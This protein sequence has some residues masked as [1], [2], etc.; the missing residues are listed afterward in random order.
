MKKVCGIVAEYNPFHSGH[1][2]HI[3]ETRRALGE[4]TVIVCVMSGNFVQRG[5]PAVFEKHVRAE[6]ALRCGADLVLELPLPWALRSA[7]GFGNGAVA[8]LAAAR[9][10]HLSFGS[11]CG[12]LEA[13]AE[14]AGILLRP[15]LDEKLRAGLAAGL[16]YPR[17]RQAAAEQLAGKPL[18]ALSRPNDLL[19]IEYL[20]AIRRQNAGLVPL[21]VRREG[22]VHDGPGSASVLRELLRRGASLKGLTPPAALAVFDRETAAGRGPVFPAALETALLS[23]LRALPETSWAALPDAAEGLENRLRRAAAEGAGIADILSAAA[24]K[25]YP[26]ARLRRMLWA[27]ALGLRRED[28]EGLPPYLRPLGANAAGRELLSSLRE[29]APLP[30]LVR[31]AA[32]RAMTGRAGRVFALEAAATDFYVLGSPAPAARRGGVEWRTPPVMA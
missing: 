17:A 10:T 12:D 7:E 11:E 27:A 16:S 22:G 20:K 18:P 14:T 28:G 19:G 24:A 30:L 15:E 8:V 25:R 9:A 4:G 2:R 21:A 6:T 23:R 13:L 31:P 3:A 32:A 29:S 26:A 5:E 1:A